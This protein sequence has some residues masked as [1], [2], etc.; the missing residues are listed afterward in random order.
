MTL[1]EL[2]A[3]LVD[4]RACPRLVAWREQVAAEKRAAFRDET[5]WDARCPAS[6]RPTR[7]CCIVGLAPAAHGGNRTGR[8]FTGDRSG[9]CAVRGAAR[10]PAWPT[11]R[12]A[13]HSA[14]AWRCS[15]PGSPRRCTARRRP[16]S[17][18]RPSATP[19]GPGW[20]ASCEL[21]APTLRAVVVLGGVRLAG[22]AAGAGA[23][24][25][26]VPA[27][28]TAA[29]GTACGAVAGRGGPLTLLGCYHVSQQN[30]FTG[31]LTARDARRRS[32]VRR[33]DGGSQDR[34]TR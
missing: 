12:L 5:Y 20:S 8:M 17:R 34:S 18:R 3:A 19:A 14:T 31:R 24:G 30:T 32:C 27:P 28:A 29:S 21:L 2:D 9:D 16:T 13:T 15:A 33:R 1:A 26:P 25:W 7:S 11:S 22:A 23:A 4:C 10:A 6:G